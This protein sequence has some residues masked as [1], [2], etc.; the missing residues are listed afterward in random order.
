MGFMGRSALMIGALVI[1]IGACGWLYLDNRSLR[2]EL[3]AQSAAR[4]T[5]VERDSSGA[6]TSDDQ[7]SEN[8]T[9]SDGTRERAGLSR[10]IFR[11]RRSERPTVEE[12][13]KKETRRERRQRRALELEAMFGR[14]DG[15]TVEEY[16]ERMVP[17]V[18]TMLEAPRQRLDDARRAAEEAAGVSDEQRAELDTALQDAYKEM[19]DLSNAAIASGDL[20]P[21]SRNW[22]GALNFA[23]GVGAVLEGAENRIGTILKPDQLDAIYDQGFEW[24]EYLGVTAPWEQLNPPPPPPDDS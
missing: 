20:T 12:E 9:A 1:S 6:E 14:L 15:E 16:R 5:A 11:N 18:K 23:G 22:S 21:Y 8:N 24:G 4:A 3:A 2:Q 17:F 10:W 7:S 13:P 19:V